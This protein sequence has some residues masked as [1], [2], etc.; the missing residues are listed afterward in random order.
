MD[1]ATV[2]NRLSFGAKS[3]LLTLCYYDGQKRFVSVGDPRRFDTVKQLIES[4]LAVC[5]SK[6]LTLVA[7][8]P[9]KIKKR[10]IKEVLCRED[11]R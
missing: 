3:L 6:V 5:N 7:T 8:I 1:L 4:N 10:L 9:N 11:K 2:V